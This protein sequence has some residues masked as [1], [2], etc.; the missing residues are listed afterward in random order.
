MLSGIASLREHTTKPSRRK[1]VGKLGHDTPSSVLEL[2]SIDLGYGPQDKMPGDNLVQT[3]LIRTFR[4]NPL[5][6]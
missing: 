6:R 3:K 2:G 4:V 5:P 1:G